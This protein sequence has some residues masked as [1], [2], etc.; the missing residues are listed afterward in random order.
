MF[1]NQ[2]ADFP[3]SISLSPGK[4]VVLRG[5]GAHSGLSLGPSIVPLLS[6]GCWLLTV[7]YLWA[8]AETCS[9]IWSVRGCVTPHAC[10][11]LSL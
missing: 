3:G 5:P 8:T 11:A 1:G 2:Q 7:A 9:W 10:R 4:I 6:H